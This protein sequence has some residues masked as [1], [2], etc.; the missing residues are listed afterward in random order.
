MYRC[1]DTFCVVHHL[2]TPHGLLHFMNVVLD[3][4][5]SREEGQVM[6]FWYFIRL[7]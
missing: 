6:S 4:I 3:V 2:A 1:W 5:H 7:E